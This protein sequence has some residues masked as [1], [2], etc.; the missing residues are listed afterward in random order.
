MMCD[1]CRA[2]MVNV[3]REIKPGHP[4]IWMD[5]WV[6]SKLDCS[7]YGTRDYLGS[8]CRWPAM[9]LMPELPLHAMIRGAMKF[10]ARVGTVDEDTPPATGPDGRRPFTP[11][12]EVW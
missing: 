12:R 8:E 1:Q 2:P 3:G 9:T 11:G 4:E 10:K 6:C 5:G 7:G